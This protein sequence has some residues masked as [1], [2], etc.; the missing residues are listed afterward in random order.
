M[1]FAIGNLGT[2]L[3]TFFL[4]PLYTF[5]LTTNEFGLVDLLTTTVTLLMPICTLSISDSVLRFVMDKKHDK[6]VILINSLLIVIVGYIFII[7]LFPLIILL[8]FNDYIVYFYILIIIQS[9]YSVFSQFVRAKGMVRLFAYSGIILALLLLISNLIFFVL[10]NMGIKGYFFSLIITYSF[11]CLLVFIK[12]GVYRELNIYK[13]NINILKE[14]L[15]YSIPLIP[16]A[17]MWWIMSFSDRFLITYFIGLSA[18][19]IY[20]VAS[21]IPSI[22][23]IVNSIFFQAWQMSAIEE[24]D[25][26]NKSKFYTNVFKIFSI[27]MF[28]STSLIIGLLKLI[29][30]LLVEDNFVDS[31]K[32]VPFLLLGVVFSSFSGFLG[33]NYIAS[34][35][36]KGVF[37]TSFLGAISNI[38]LNLSLIPFFG[39]NGASIAT[40]ISFLIIWIFRIRD[41]K[42][43]VDIK[44]DIKK[45]ILN[46]SIIIIQIIILYMNIKMNLILQMSM[47]LVIIILNNKEVMFIFRKLK[48][49]I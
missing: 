15:S 29:M 5:Y 37:K 28:L 19:G 3:I 38:L 18:N 12:G 26:E 31:W 24:Y 23:N 41:T 39:I 27:L 49:R 36:T 43:Y 40:M 14:M 35:K 34:K 16:N 10:F 32:Y 44:L 9:I 42:R 47:F 6:Q 2:K 21:K 46:I 13:I 48:N 4:V 11:S 33:T 22:L 1:V 30:H 20:A 17:L 8:P 7:V 45:L 25:S